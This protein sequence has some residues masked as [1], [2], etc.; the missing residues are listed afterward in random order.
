M[1]MQ[2]QLNLQ[3]GCL[4]FCHFLDWLQGRSEVGN[5]TL[6]WLCGSKIKT[7]NQSSILL[8][9]NNKKSGYLCIFGH[10]AVLSYISQ[11]SFPN[12]ISS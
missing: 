12:Y 5:E 10:L 1:K 3:H 11:G 6:V 9:E 2:I 8:E 7:S 4:D